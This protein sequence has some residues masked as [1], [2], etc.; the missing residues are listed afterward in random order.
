MQQSLGLFLGALDY[1]AYSHN[2]LDAVQCLLE[3]VDP[4]VGVE[5]K[6]FR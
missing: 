5:L 3:S 4:S 1:D 2:L 6:P